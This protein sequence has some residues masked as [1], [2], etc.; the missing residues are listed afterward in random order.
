[1]VTRLSLVVGKCKSVCDAPS[2][3]EISSFTSHKDRSMDRIY[4]SDTRTLY[5]RAM[6]SRRKYDRYREFRVYL[7]DERTRN[8]FHVGPDIHPASNLCAWLFQN[9]RRD[10]AKRVIEILFQIVKAASFF[11]H[12]KVYYEMHTVRY[13]VRIFWATFDYF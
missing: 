1:M 9:I 10:C 2:S 6:Y 13:I 8:A 3:V 11:H 12:K 5:S 7:C 4:Q